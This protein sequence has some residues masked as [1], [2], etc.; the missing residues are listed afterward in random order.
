[1]TETTTA[2]KVLNL[3]ELELAES[4]IGIVHEG[5]KHVMRTLTVELF[6]EQQKR[7][8]EHQRLVAA[9]NFTSD[10]NDITDIVS[11]IRD[12]VH[13]FFPTLPVDKLETPKLFRIF[14]WLNDM[15]EKVNDDGAAT[16]EDAEGNAEPVATES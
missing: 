1:M 9:G 6:I 8:A 14:G 5:K 11:L 15:S 13:E 10:D 7:A 12:A 4:E 2:P 16:V 3:D